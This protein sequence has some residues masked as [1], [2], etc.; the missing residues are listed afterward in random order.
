MTSGAHETNASVLD[1]TPL[2]S[3]PD[4]RAASRVD[5]AADSG[6]DRGSQHG[7]RCVS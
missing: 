1:Q 3:S 4:G 7:R 2:V 6:G 5:F